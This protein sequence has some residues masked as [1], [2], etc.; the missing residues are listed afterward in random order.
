M[1]SEKDIPYTSW[2]LNPGSYDNQFWHSITVKHIIRQKH[3]IFELHMYLL[4]G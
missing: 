4:S 3:L 2:D 1:E